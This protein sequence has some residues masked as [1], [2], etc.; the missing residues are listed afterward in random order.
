MSR[1]RLTSSALSREI[2]SHID[3]ETEYVQEPEG[4]ERG[5][6]LFVVRARHTQIHTNTHKQEKIT[7]IFMSKKD[8]LIINDLSKLDK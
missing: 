1:S 3:I 5:L 2:S 6:I 8:L 7:L 4:C